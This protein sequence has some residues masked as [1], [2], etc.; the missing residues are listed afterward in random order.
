MLPDPSTE[1]ADYVDV[2]TN[3]LTDVQTQIARVDSKA[4]IL[5]SFALAG[6]TGGG[7]IVAKGAL[8]PAATV[9]AIVAGLLIV[10]ASVLLGSAIRP[11]LGGRHGFIRWSAAPDVDHLVADL[12]ALST[13]GHHAAGRLWDLSRS[14]RRKYARV[15]LA[16]DLLGAAFAVVILTAVL[17]FTS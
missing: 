7:A 10:T 17:A 16:V 14:V 5:F 15:R 11:A 2:L 1:A 12:Q 4:S 3:A 13:D 6:L 9:T 8:P